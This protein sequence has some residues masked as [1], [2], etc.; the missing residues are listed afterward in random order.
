M[1]SHSYRDANSL[2][3]SVLVIGCG[4]S[5]RDISFAAAKAAE[6]VI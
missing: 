5:G 6:K 1:H 4:A 3:N 2:G